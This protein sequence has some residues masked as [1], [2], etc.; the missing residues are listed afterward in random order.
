MSWVKYW[1]WNPRSFFWERA[2]TVAW[3][4]ASS[5]LES[6]PITDQAGNLAADHGGDVRHLCLLDD[7][8][9]VLFMLNNNI[10]IIDV[11]KALPHDPRMQGLTWAITRSAEYAA[12]MVTS[13][14]IPRLINR[15]HPAETLDQ[16][17]LMGS[18]R[19]L[20]RLEHPIYSLG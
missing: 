19:L 6:G 11:Y 12:A 14:E 3:E 2:C 5:H 16:A 4:A 7:G 9:Q 8:D 13:T 17:T 20:N 18:L 10:H 1:E 15:N